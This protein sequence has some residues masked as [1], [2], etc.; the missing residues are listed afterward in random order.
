MKTEPMLWDGQGNH[1]GVILLLLSILTAEVMVYSKAVGPP[2][3]CLN[4]GSHKY[5][6]KQQIQQMT[7]R[8]A[9]VQQTVSERKTTSV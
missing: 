8:S 1:L 6:N 7:H 2:G 4:I 3:H 9:E 5:A